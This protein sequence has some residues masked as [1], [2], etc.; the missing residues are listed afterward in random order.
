MSTRQRYSLTESLNRIL[1]SL[2]GKSI[3]Q[4]TPG[5]VT[6]E[7]LSPNEAVS[8]LA[9]LL[10]NSL[11][12]ETLTLPT[13][14]TNSV[15]TLVAGVDE[16]NEGTSDTVLLTPASHT[17]AHEYG[18]ISTTSGT[19]YMVLAA[20]TWTKVTGTFQGYMLDSGAEVDCDWNDDRVIINEAGTYFVTYSLSVLNNGNA[21]DLKVQIFAS[22]SAQT[23]TRSYIQFGASGTVDGSKMMVGMGMVSAPVAD[24][25]VDVRVNASV[26][27]VFK[28]EAGQLTVTK[29]VG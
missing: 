14:V 21:A 20:D 2:E 1:R 11:P 22:G 5:T 9:E 8:D 25:P 24:W 26:A 4:D 12:G 7:V 16:A 27:T 3:S 18:G 13:A 29:M 17:W 15:L 28:A 10:D 19:S 23:Q 6:G